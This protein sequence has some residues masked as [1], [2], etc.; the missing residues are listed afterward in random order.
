MTADDPAATS[1]DGGTNSA[2]E[3]KPNS[4]G[5]FGISGLTMEPGQSGAGASPLISS[6][7]KAVHLDSGIRLL[8]MTQ[9][10]TTTSAQ[11]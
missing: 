8:L 1:V 6:T 4:R 7:G 2:G 10:Q 11:Q 5:V 3:L 9:A